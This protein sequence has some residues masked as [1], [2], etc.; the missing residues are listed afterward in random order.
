[1]VG[2]DRNFIDQL[3]FIYDHLPWPSFLA[4]SKSRFK[5]AARELPPP[6]GSFPNPL[7][8]LDIVVDESVPENEIRFV[9]RK[10][11]DGEYVGVVDKIV[12]IGI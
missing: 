5:E 12:N 7:F 4:V 3:K 9:S 8:G 6:S 2:M 11:V 10:L 1:M